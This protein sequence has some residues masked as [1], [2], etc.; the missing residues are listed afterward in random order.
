[1]A[2]GDR[3][4]T[5]LRRVGIIATLAGACAL[6]GA[7]AVLAAD[8]E[9]P[10]LASTPA[11]PASTAPRPLVYAGSSTFGPWEHLDE[12]G[13]PDGFNVALIRA[14][15]RHT[16]RPIEVRLTAW[17]QVLGGLDSGAVDLAAVGASDARRARYDYLSLIWTLQQSVIGR[18]DRS[19]PLPERLT[20][21]AREVVVVEQGSLMHEL[22]VELP[23]VNRPLL[24]LAPNQH[25]GLRMLLDGNASLILGNALVLRRAA[26]VLDARELPSREIK[27]AG[28]HFVTGRGRAPEFDWLEPALAQLKEN[29]TFARAFEQYLTPEAPPARVSP[30]TL[31]LLV[32]LALAGLVGALAWYRRVRRMVASKVQ[33]EALSARRRREAEDALRATER[34]IQQLVHS[35][36]A[37]VWRRDV[38]TGRYSFVS[39]EAEQLLG[40]PATSWTDEPDFVSRIRHP[41]DDEWVRR[42]SQRATAERRD[43]TMEYRVQTQDGRL[44]W[45]RDIVSVIVE[46]GE[47][48]EL[49]GVMIDISEYKAAEEALE[50]AHAQALAATRA[51]SEFLASMS[52]EIR[53][54]MNAVIGITDLLL[55][56]PLS[57]EQHSLVETVRSSGDV[58]L[59]VINDILDF[60]KVESGKL[61]FERIAF[62]PEALADDVARLMGERAT[63]KGL[64]LTC[65]IAADVPRNLVGDPG[66]LRQVL[67]NLVG[68]AIKFTET[69]DV[70]IRVTAPSI[71]DGLA[72]LRVEVSDTGIGIAPEAQA[73]LFDAF[74]QADASTTRRY[75]GTGLGLAISKRIIELLGGAIGIDSRIGEGTTFWFTIPCTRSGHL[76]EPVDTGA[77]GGLRVL[78]A[79]DSRASRVMLEQTLMDAGMSVQVARDADEALALIGDGPWPHVAL[80][81]EGLTDGGGLRLAERL[82]ARAPHP[83]AVVLLASRPGGTPVSLERSA[84]LMKPVRRSELFATLE[85]LGRPVAAQVAPPLPAPRPQSGAGVPR[86]NLRVLVAEDNLVNQKVARLMLEKCGC[87]VEVVADGAQAVAAVQAGEFDLVL[88]DCQMPVCDGF[89]ATRRIRALPPPGNGVVI[90][91]LTANALAGDREHCLAAG[92]NDYLAKPV[93]REALAEMLARYAPAA[94]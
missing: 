71:S 15:S 68:N 93:R 6:P 14:L 76:P 25:D 86:P 60:S 87:R 53:T 44:V 90:V 20:D 88:M 10:A 35:V 82:R 74:T 17:A 33:A 5:W 63:A 80:I 77:L 34:Q 70:A 22:M 73:R 37:I 46:Q 42:Y 12:H 79:D 27:A 69:G 51:K 26:R 92:M 67:L 59:N 30:W 91:A 81:D 48:R 55:D 38:A 45:L 64:D 3:V 54:P 32:A 62:D 2:F 1:M 94:A 29:G 56:S 58:L 36:K 19:T 43:H 39:Q 85:R 24:V 47:P 41:D 72:H 61:E 40:Y 13:R 75:G 83:P 7:T 66:R 31:V 18:P 4:T 84:R 65:R 89:E 11:A 8:P 23:E 52:H 28:Y 16:G 49:I 78:V 50:A 9:P 57:P 21:L